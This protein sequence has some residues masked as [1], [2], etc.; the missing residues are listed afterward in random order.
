MDPTHEE[1]R[2]LVE[3]FYRRVR[4][5]PR[6]GPIFERHVADWDQHTE[7]LTDF[8]HSLMLT[9]GRYK[10]N[11]FAVHRAFAGE[12]DMDLFDRWLSLWQAATQETFPPELAARFQFKAS[13]VAESFK[14]GLLFDPAARDRDPGV[15]R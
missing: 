7:R 15:T 8:W 11:P 4:S 1:I 5:D 13:R 14:A 2:A 12:L 9:S 10:G 3:A 6:L